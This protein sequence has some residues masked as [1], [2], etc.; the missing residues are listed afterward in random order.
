MFN[1]KNTLQ[2]NN[3]FQ[4]IKMKSQFYKNFVVII[5]NLLVVSQS[6]QAT[7]I[8]EQAFGTHSSGVVSAFG[9]FNSDELTDIFLITNNSRTLQILYGN[10]TTNYQCHESISHL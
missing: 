3:D 4:E 6:S 1:L 7:N 9:D 2:E 5:F 10:V 8:T